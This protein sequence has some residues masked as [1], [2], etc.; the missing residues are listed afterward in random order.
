MAE[1]INFRD[2]G[3]HPVP[4]GR[5]VRTDRLYRC[6]QF[7]GVGAPAV[8]RLLGMDFALIA[9]LRYETEQRRHPSPWPDSYAGRILAHGE[10]RPTAPHLTLL[11]RAG[12]DLEA[13]DRFYL[14][15]YRS[16]P[17]DALYRPLFARVIAAI[18]AEQGR[19]LIH[20]A[21]GKDRT[22]LLCSLVLDTLG[23][24]RPAILA[25]YLASAR[26]PGLLALK[27]GIIASTAERHG[28]VLP[29]EVVDA[30][31]GVK[32][33]YLDAAFAEIEAREGSVAAYLQASG[34]TQATQDALRARLLA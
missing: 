23:V 16:L 11:S 22:G 3:G 34:V 27:P 31:I 8:D 15:F 12:L 29:E 30:L 9:D 18:A 6:G 13:V 24:E 28:H 14:D 20:C 17:F 1:L 32:T 25:D 21:A 10:D 2:F 33:A 19:T 5:R 26:A 7:E 4:D